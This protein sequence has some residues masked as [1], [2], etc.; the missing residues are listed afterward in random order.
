MTSLKMPEGILRPFRDAL[1]ERKAKEAR[2]YEPAKR[3]EQFTA[4]RNRT[5]KLNEEL[6]AAVDEQRAN[7]AAAE[8]KLQKTMQDLEFFQEEINK[9]VAETNSTAAAFKRVSEPPPEMRGI[10]TTLDQPDEVL[11]VHP[12]YVAYAKA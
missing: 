12:D 9:A 10:R 7:L 3:L 8:A 4:Q 11:A 6:Q 2:V 1:E 5:L